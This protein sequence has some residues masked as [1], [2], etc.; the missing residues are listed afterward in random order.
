ME[1]NRSSGGDMND[2]KVARRRKAAAIAAAAAMGSTA[3]AA[4]WA[5][6]AEA[7]HP[8]DCSQHYFCE[9]SDAGFNGPIRYWNISDDN[10]V[11]NH[12]NNGP[13]SLTL[14]DTVS[15]VYNNT[16]SHWVKIFNNAH[17]SGFSLC[18]PPGMASSNLPSV[19]KDP[20]S[21]ASLGSNNWNDAASSH[22][23]YTF[24]PS[25]CDNTLNQRG[26]SM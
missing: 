5:P 20:T 3:V 25:G 15:A 1:L 26:C 9:W 24:S 4:V 18:V 13:D 12:Y 22:Y 21:T 17:G 7:N 10:Y 14:N 6:G 23:L 19:K 2:L 16:T 8:T 11:G